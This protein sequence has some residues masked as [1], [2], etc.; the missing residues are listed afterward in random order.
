MQ[1]VYR[2]IPVS[3]CDLNKI[4]WQFYW[5]HTLAWLF[6]CKFA[7]YFQ[8]TFY[9]NTLL[10]CFWTTFIQLCK[11][12]PLA[13]TLMFLCSFASD[14]AH[15]TVDSYSMR[16]IHL[17]KLV[18]DCALTALYLSFYGVRYRSYYSNSPQTSSRF[19]LSSTAT[20]VLYATGLT[21]WTSHP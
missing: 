11:F 18:F 17:W 14:L 3:K 1:D 6:S 9:K 12:L 13:N 5:N 7:A 10:G 8:N 21:K 19:E 4:A 20:Q 16:F 15:V 2:V